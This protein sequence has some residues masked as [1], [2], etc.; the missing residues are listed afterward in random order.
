MRKILEKLFIFRK[1]FLSKYW[2]IHYS[3]FGEDV[4]LKDWIRKDY[5]KGYF[6]DV[7][8][9]HPRKFSNTYFLYKRGWRGINIDLDSLKIASM[10]M[11]RSKDINIIAA[12]SDKKEQVETYTDSKY[13]LGATI[14][15]SVAS[16]SQKHYKSHSI[17][18]Q[19]LDEIINSTKYKNK[20]ID[21]L[22]IDVE[23]Y[24]YNALLSLNI[25]KYKPKLI[26]IEDTS[27]K[28]IQSI[29]RTDIYKFLTTKNYRMANWAGH[30]LF[31]ISK[32]GCDFIKKT[33]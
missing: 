30:T 4:V 1:S 14:N 3:Q 9:Y 18:T 15:P 29:I 7:G 31:F 27:K 10:N 33:I 24:D 22:T 6:V 28:D 19:T 8:C 17:T 32:E 21:L 2:Q 5:K 23:G 26:L 12:V 25:D 16:Q 20:E 13:S 11:V